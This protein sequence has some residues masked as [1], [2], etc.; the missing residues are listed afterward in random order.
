MTI[1]NGNDMSDATPLEGEHMSGHRTLD[2]QWRVRT[3]REQARAAGVGGAVMD[4]RFY[5]SA[6][7]GPLQ[8]RPTAGAPFSSQTILFLADA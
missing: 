4:N 2:D 1:G 3:A 5:K 7:R 6:W 8:H